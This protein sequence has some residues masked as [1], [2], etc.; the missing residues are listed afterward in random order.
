MRTFKRICIKPHTV[1]DGK[2]S[3]TVERGKEY[4]TSVVGCSAAIGPDPQDGMVV[5][6]GEF[7]AHFPVDI[8]GGEIIHT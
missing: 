5:V 4:T 6:F 1:T 3:M 8:F 2:N 7:W